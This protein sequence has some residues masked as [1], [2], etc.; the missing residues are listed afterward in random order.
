MELKI[1]LWNGWNFMSVFI[2]QMLVMM[3]GDKN[4]Q[5]RTHIPP[6]ARRN[7]FERSISTIAN[8]VWLAALIYSVFLPLRLH[9]HWFTVG[10]SIFILGVIFLAAASWSFMT[11]AIDAPITGGIYRLSRHPMYLA[12]FLVSLGT[13]IAT[14][15]WIFILLS[16]LM[17]LCFRQEALLEERICLEQYGSEYREYMESVP[18]WLGVPR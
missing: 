1:G 4:A 7:K 10:I 8:L 12:T 5:K 18:R 16:V 11:A 3:L 6:K 13:G 2:L 14:V 15:S 9:T 17:A